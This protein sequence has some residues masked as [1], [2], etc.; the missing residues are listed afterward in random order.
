MKLTY[1]DTLPKRA[2]GGNHKLQKM[3][4]EFIKSEQEIAKIDLRPDDYKS[5]DVANTTISGACKRSG[6]PVKCVRRSNELYL[7][8]EWV[9]D[10][11]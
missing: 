6:H 5:I 9:L 4:D 8:R 3:I 10:Q 2:K 1:V 11:E 7:V